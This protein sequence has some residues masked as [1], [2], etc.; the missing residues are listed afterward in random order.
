MPLLKYLNQKGAEVTVFDNREEKDIPKEGLKEI[1]DYN[2][3][4]YFGKN[5][6]ENLHGFNMI[7]RAPSCMPNIKEL[8]EERK[9]GA[10]ITSEIEML[11][12]LCPG[13]IVRSNRK[14]WQN[15]NNNPYIWNIKNG[16][17]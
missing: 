9:N 7:F 13:T 10:I 5:S 4:H 11:M 2:M 14:W 6:L 16:R 3:E 15:N 12:K 1:S 8:E 17:I